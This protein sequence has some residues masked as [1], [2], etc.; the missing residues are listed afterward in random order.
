MTLDLVTDKLNAMSIE[1]EKEEGKIIL[2]TYNQEFSFDPY[3]EE[4]K[5]ELGYIAMNKQNT[6]IMNIIKIQLEN[7][8]L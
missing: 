6:I 4:L 7:D 2:K 5:T 8:D 1:Y 3:S